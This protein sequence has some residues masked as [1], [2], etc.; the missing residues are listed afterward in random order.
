VTDLERAKHRRERLK[1]LDDVL[2]AAKEMFKAAQVGGHESWY[3]LSKLKK[4][5]ERVEQFDKTQP[6][7]EPPKAG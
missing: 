3:A 2:K 1:L 4:C 6:A 5:V 7:P